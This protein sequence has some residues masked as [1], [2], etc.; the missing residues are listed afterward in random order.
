MNFSTLSGT[1]PLIDFP[2]LN[3][4]LISVDETS[5]CRV[6]NVSTPFRFNDGRE[7]FV[8]PPGLARYITASVASSRIRSGFRHRSKLASESS[9]SKRKN[10]EPSKRAVSPSKV[11]TVKDNP[12]RLISV[13]STA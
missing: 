1:N 10:R 9:P 5:T 4:C 13:S 8:P 11:S 12:S 6:D 2:S 3:L 7:V